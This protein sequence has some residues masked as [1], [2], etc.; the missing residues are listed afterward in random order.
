MWAAT[1]ALNNTTL[2]A[3]ISGDWG[4]HRM[5]HVLSFLYD[6]PHAAT[7]SIL[8]PAWIKVMRDR[9]KERIEALGLALY[10]SRTRTKSVS[11]LKDFFSRALAAR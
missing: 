2:Y 6:T 3:R 8:Y 7:L 5:G 9:A 1:N 10:G 11:N 4:V